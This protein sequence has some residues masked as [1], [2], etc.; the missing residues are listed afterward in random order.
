MR[1]GHRGWAQEAAPAVGWRPGYGVDEPLGAGRPAPAFRIG[2]DPLAW[3]RLG[4]R[5]RATRWRG[6]GLLVSALLA[7]GGCSEPV[8]SDLD[9]P[10]AHEAVRVLAA[11]GIAAERR[12]QGRRHRVEVDPDDLPRAWAA[13]QRAEA[14]APPAATPAPRRWVLSP[15]EARLAARAAQARTLGETLRAL[16]GVVAARVSLD[17]ASAAVVLR[18]EPGAPTAGEVE[19]LVRAGAGLG[20]GAPI[21]VAR[22]P[23]DGAEPVGDRSPSASPSSHPPDPAAPRPG[24]LGS[25]LRRGLGAT[26]SA[27][28]MGGLALV[29]KRRRKRLRSR[30]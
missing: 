15:T 21:A 24:A 10:A 6:A 9:A 28:A 27:L 29:L 4:A 13:L 16:P 30:A 19:A 20:P 3:L 2:T 26:A 22:H 18:V 1:P 11:A 14:L 23:A 25:G 7:L 12:G 5:G 17:A 8:L